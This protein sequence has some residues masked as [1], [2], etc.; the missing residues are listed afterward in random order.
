MYSVIVD[1]ATG[2]DHTVTDL[3]LILRPNP[4]I[5]GVIT[6]EINLPIAEDHTIHYKQ[7]HLLPL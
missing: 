1:D 3:Q 4:S 6:N 5:T 2:P 7:L